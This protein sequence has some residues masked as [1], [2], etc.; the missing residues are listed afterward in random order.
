MSLTLDLFAD[1]EPSPALD[2][3]ALAVEGERLRVSAERSRSLREDLDFTNV[4]EAYCG[5]SELPSSA[6]EPQATSVH[7]LA[8]AAIACKHGHEDKSLIPIHRNSGGQNF[9][10]ETE[11]ARFANWLICG[12]RSDRP[13]MTPARWAE[14]ISI[15]KE[16]SLMQ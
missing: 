14:A 13:S 12:V 1:P 6:S 15:V 8:F 11:L 5:K 7:A 4:R 3:A 9:Y 2:L 16:R 10:D